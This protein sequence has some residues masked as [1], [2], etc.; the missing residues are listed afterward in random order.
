MRRCSMSSIEEED[1]MGIEEMNDWDSEISE[2]EIEFEDDNE[3]DPVDRAANNA[4]KNF[5][6]NC[7]K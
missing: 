7:T 2:S 4:L 6:A 3:E 5:I 1:E